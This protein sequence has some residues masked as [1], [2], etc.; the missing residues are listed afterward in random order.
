MALLI[1]VSKQEENGQFPILSLNKPE[2]VP[3]TGLSQ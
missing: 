2:R 1:Y 3:A